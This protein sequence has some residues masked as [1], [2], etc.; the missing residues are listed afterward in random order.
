M[1]LESARVTG[2]IMPTVLIVEDDVI[3]RTDLAEVLSD[4]GYVVEE[5]SNGRDALEKLRE[6]TSRPAVVL[7]DLMTPIMNGW[8]FRAAQLD[9]PSISDI[10][11]VVLSGA[12]DVRREARALG[13]IAHLKKPFG[14]DDLLG[15]IRRVLAA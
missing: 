8:E 5:A 4:A 1:R 2:S 7:L 12:G 6:R 15:I 14:L 13:A 9:D 3:I 11:V 10:P